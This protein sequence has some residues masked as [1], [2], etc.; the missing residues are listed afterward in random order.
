VLVH[1]LPILPTSIHLTWRLAGQGRSA[2]PRVGVC[3]VATLLE[4]IVAE[5]EEKAEKPDAVPY[6]AAKKPL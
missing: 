2:S 4:I 6:H 1:V 3:V 5:E